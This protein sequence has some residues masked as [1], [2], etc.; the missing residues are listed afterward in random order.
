M[1][2]AFDETRLAHRPDLIQNDLATHLLEHAVHTG[3]VIVLTLG[4]SGFG[5]DRFGN[6][7]KGPGDGFDA[8]FCG[9]A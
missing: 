4:L 5:G 6:V 2:Q 1:P 3:W 9:E 7:S 8:V